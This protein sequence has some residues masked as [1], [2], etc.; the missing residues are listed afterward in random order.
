MG[1]PEE[2]LRHQL[3]AENDC[4]D[5]SILPSMA[6]CMRGLVDHYYPLRS[7]GVPWKE[8]YEFAAA[9]YRMGRNRFDAKLA[10]QPFPK[11]A[12]MYDQIPKD[13]YDYVS[14]SRDSVVW[15]YRDWAWFDRNYKPPK[16]G[17]GLWALLLAA[18]AVGL[19]W[20]KK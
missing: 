13:V 18:L 20:K 9:A 3:V 2:L 11:W 7:I 16:K 12:L 10:Q 6:K 8:I 1:L 15:D 19:I 4:Q 17:A 5:P 14:G